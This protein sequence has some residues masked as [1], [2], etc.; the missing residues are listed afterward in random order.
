MTM[1]QLQ[2]LLSASNIGYSAASYD[3]LYTSNGILIWLTECNSN[4]VCNELRFS[5]TF[6]DV[7]PTLEA[8]NQW[9]YE[10]KIPEAS[11]T[12]EGK[13]QFEMWMT[14]IGMTDVSFNDTLGWFDSAWRNEEFWAPYISSNGV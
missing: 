2:S 7:Q 5:R 8:V 13:L 14:T 9:N 12:P 3:T 10:Y 11:R 6:K 4:S 1:P